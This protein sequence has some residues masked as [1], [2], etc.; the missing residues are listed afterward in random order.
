MTT[1]ED[2]FRDPYRVMLAASG[3]VVLFI[4]ALR[5]LT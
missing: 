4:A 1:P 5:V 3:A 2:P